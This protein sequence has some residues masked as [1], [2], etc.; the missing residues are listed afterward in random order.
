MYNTLQKNLKMTQESLTGCKGVYKLKTSLLFH[1]PISADGFK[2]ECERRASPALMRDMR[3]LVIC[4]IVTSWLRWCWSYHTRI[5]TF[6][7]I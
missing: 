2:L 6:Q 5:T 3:S 7:N 4:V 1:G